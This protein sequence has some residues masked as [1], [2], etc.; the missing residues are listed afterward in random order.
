MWYKL[1][2]PRWHTLVGLSER[3]EA[4]YGGV[5]YSQGDSISAR[6]YDTEK[7]DD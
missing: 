5:L 4:E 7:L 1:Y 6:H 2:M 3:G